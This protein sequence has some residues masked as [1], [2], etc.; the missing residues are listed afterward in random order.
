[1]YKLLYIEGIMLIIPFISFTSY[2]ILIQKVCFDKSAVNLITN[3]LSDF[4]WLLGQ[5]T[6]KAGTGWMPYLQI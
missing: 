5:K 4:K 2:P 6:S 3:Y 1:M